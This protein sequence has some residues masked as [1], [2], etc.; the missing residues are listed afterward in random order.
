MIRQSHNYII[1]TI[2]IITRSH[3]PFDTRTLETQCDMGYYV[4][5]TTLPKYQCFCNIPA[6]IFHSKPTFQ[7][8]DSPIDARVYCYFIGNITVLLLVKVYKSTIP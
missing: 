1:L 5:N 3:N 8:L 2:L 6:Y 7:M 4:A